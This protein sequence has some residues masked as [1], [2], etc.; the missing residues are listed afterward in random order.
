MTISRNV[1]ADLLPLYASGECSEDTRG[2]V[3][4]YAR[5]HPDVRR[6]IA[7]LKAAAGGPAPRLEQSAEGK[8]LARTRK[9]LR[10]RSSILAV[11][12]FF[13]IAP[14][15][16][17]SSNGQFIWLLRDSPASAAAY[18]ALAVLSWVA[19]VI[20]RKKTADL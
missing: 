13:T 10:L 5:D 9:R 14:F 16:F 12:I 18:G 17:L 15:S 3:E 11:A 7:A 2:L 19:Y 4:E 20:L 8:A 1:I 6:E